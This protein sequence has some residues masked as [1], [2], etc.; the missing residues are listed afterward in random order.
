MA[1][2]AG[3]RA[4]GIAANAALPEELTWELDESKGEMVLQT[5]GLAHN[6]TAAN[7]VRSGIIANAVEASEDIALGVAN[8]DV[9]VDHRVYGDSE[10]NDMLDIIISNYTA[11][12]DNFK[13]TCAVYLDQEEEPYYVNLP[14]YARALADRRTHTITMPV[15]ALLP[16]NDAH[17][18]ARVVISAIDRQ[19]SAF[20]NNEFTI[21]LDG[22]GALHIVEQPQDQ[23]VQEGEDVS[24]EVEVAGGTKPYSYQW[25]VWD[26]KHQK[27]VDLPG[28]TGPTLSRKN[29][30]KKWDGCRFRCVITDA[31]GD[32][33]ITNEVTLTVRDKVPTG[34]SSNLPLYLAVAMV[35]LI[36]LWIVRK[37]MRRAQ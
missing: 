35:A 16:E 37:R 33:V 19:E 21:H 32:Q 13:L 34:D 10:G 5:S 36:L 2:A 15:R 20:A 23:T 14:Y 3:A 26:E 24:F 31:N 25:Q 1:N 4:N 7:A 27:W 17:Y 30:E 18:Q 12:Q 28:F 9:E 29:I 6:G 11:T 8:Q 22:G